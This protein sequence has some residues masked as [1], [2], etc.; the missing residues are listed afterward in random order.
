V[1]T[2][3]DDDAPLEIESS[4]VQ[5]GTI[6]YVELSGGTPGEIYTVT[7]SVTTSDADL[8]A[9]RFRVKVEDRYL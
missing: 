1:S 5:G 3:E 2:V 4:G 6:T 7:C 9:R 8:D